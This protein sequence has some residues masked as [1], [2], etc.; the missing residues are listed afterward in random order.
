MGSSE[1]SGRGA[2]FMDEQKPPD[3][4]EFKEL[5]ELLNAVGRV[6]EKEEPSKQALSPT[7][8]TRS[9]KVEG[10]NRYAAAI[11]SMMSKRTIDR[12]LAVPE[13]TRSADIK[14]NE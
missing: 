1:R 14:P 4:H 2:V 3:N 5:L 6:P 7:T 11:V 9:R 8:E 13:L 10:E 12:T